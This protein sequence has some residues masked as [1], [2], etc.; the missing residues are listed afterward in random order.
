MNIKN[1]SLNFFNSEGRKVYTFDAILEIEFGRT[2]NAV[3]AASILIPNL[4]IYNINEFQRNCTLEI[5]RDGKIIPVLWYFK[6]ATITQETIELVFFD[7][8]TLLDQRYVTWYEVDGYN[9]PSH[10]RMEADEMI[11]EIIRT[12]L[13]T[14][15]NDDLG[16]SPISIPTTLAAM[17]VTARTM[18]FTLVNSLSEATIIE[19]SAAWVKVLQVVQNIAKTAESNGENIWF[20][21]TY[22]PNIDGYTLGRLSFHVWF[23]LRGSDLR[24]GQVPN[25]SV[26]SPELGNLVD[27]QM[28]IDYENFYNQVYVLA[29]ELPEVDDGIQL[30]RIVAYPE[31]YENIGINLYEFVEQIDDV[32][33]NDDAMLARAKALYQ[34]GKEIRRLTGNIIQVP[35]SQFFKHY[36]FGDKVSAYWQN[37]F[38]ETEIASYNITIGETEEIR[39][40]FN[41]NTQ[42]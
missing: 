31:T 34:S 18:P 38:F 9:Y 2:K 21:F 23:G 11:T 30:V 32:E 39:I 40:P 33:T 36:N 10:L 24:I 3:G 22:I 6:K 42:V 15:V 25:P 14:G 27:Y 29:K 26:F 12:N 20:D 17:G 8:L 5:Y 7:H 19:N 4:N 35:S 1:Y 28:E 41:T 37:I 13:G 16:Y